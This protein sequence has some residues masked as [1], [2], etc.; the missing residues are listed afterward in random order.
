MPYI[1]YLYLRAFNTFRVGFGD[2]EVKMIPFSKCRCLIRP[3]TNLMSLISI[4]YHLIRISYVT[5]TVV[6]LRTYWG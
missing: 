4:N 2:V 3:C 1:A 5:E 6:Y